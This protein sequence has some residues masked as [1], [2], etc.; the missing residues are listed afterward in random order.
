[1]PEL[2]WP[3]T[4]GE[5]AVEIRSK[6][7]GP[8]WVTIEAFMPDDEAYRT[9]EKMITAAAIARLYRVA[10]EQVQL[11]TLPHLGVI[12]ASFPR[13]VSQGSLHDRDMHAGQQHIP[14]AALP[15]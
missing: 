14:L 15:L 7:A 9:A 5:L 10:P 4:L 8:F 6:N 12:K 2:G 1:M 13:P 3:A 11:F